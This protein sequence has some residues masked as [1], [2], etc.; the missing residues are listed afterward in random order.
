MFFIVFVNT[1]IMVFLLNKDYKINWRSKK[2]FTYSRFSN[3]A[4]FFAIANIVIAN[5]LL[6]KIYNKYFEQYFSK[7]MD[8]VYKWFIIPSFC[9]FVF[10]SVF[11]ATYSIFVFKHENKIRDE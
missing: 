2:V 4:R 6:S 1:L 9:I 3:I 11:Y 7:T 5:E 8:T 10:L